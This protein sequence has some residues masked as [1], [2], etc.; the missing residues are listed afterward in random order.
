MF[1]PAG[2]PGPQPRCRPHGFTL[3]EVLVVL[4]VIG[5]VL[6]MVLPSFKQPLGGRGLAA[7]AHEVAAAF[8]LARNRAIMEDRLIQFASAEQVFDFGRGPSAH[9]P[10]GIALILI[11][12][13]QTPS[14]RPISF[15]PD[16]SSSGGGVALA[17]GNSRYLV[18][19]NWID[20]DVAIRS[21]PLQPHP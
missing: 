13:R 7:T 10:A 15:Y 19:V 20:G 11:D 1:S 18:L 17:A 3:I 8:R 2:V 9:V 14:A 12:S 4:A 21:A 6:A 5:F 16:G